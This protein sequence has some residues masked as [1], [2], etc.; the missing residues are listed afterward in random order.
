MKMYSD[1]P[2]RR[3]R[4]I[5][6]DAWLVLWSVLWIWIAI[7]LHGLVMNLATP[8][9]AM[10]AGATSMAG[11]IDSAGQSVG[12]LPLVGESLQT[13]FQGMGDAARAIASAGQSEVEAVSALAMFLSVA[14]AILAIAS[15]AVFWIPLR[16]AFIR[17]ATAARELAHASDDLDL[18]ALRALARQP[19][20]VLVRIDPDPAAAWRRGDPRVTRA[21]AELELRSEGLR[22]PEPKSV[23]G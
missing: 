9:Q 14:L 15:Y 8:G 11:S 2:A 10:A 4:Q 13:P 6:G 5:L 1:I 3:T 20:H 19:L 7:T 21:L 16:L 22:A 18:F 23:G 12:G 17:K